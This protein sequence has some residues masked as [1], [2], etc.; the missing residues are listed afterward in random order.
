M[1]EKF[2]QKEIP[3]DN[4]EELDKHK[5]SI[6]DTKFNKALGALMKVPKPEK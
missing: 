1:N 3:F 4:I 5:K 2:G 6:D